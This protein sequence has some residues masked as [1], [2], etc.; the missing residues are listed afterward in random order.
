M[1]IALRALVS[2]ALLAAVIVH[3]GNESLL[4]S[5]RR[6][7]ARWWLLVP[8]LV[9]PPAFGYA[10]GVLR[11]RAL[12][13]AQ[14][15]RLGS[16]E[17]LRAMLIGTLFNQ[18]LP[19]SVGGDASRVWY[20]VRRV[21]QLPAVLS[22]VLLGRAM[23]VA[24]LCILVIT[25]SVI[26]PVWFS[27]I[28]ALRYCVGVLV[29]V[30]MAAAVAL[31]WIRAP[32]AEPGVDRFGLRRAW[33]KLATAFAR[34]RQHRTILAKTLLYSL[35]LQA[36][37]VLQYWLFSLCLGV[38]VSFDRFLVAVPLVSL[39]AM[40]PFSLNGIGIRECVMIWICAPLGITQGDAAVIAW[41]FVAGGL[42][43]AGVGAVVLSRSMT[44]GRA[45]TP[46]AAAL[47]RSG[48]N[49]DARG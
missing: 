10:M 8:S 34:F 30:L 2:V 17:V 15:V 36:E 39:A 43:Y 16:G 49:H 26:H 40:A 1:K 37:I 22:S 19:T 11:L 18:L 6:A 35:A 12:F 33:F 23:G 7:G 14:R 45:D 38:D 24:A 41:L 27:Q 46:P 48:T 25:G 5:L 31:A 29:G 28:P 47:D 9:M 42:F 13:R 32:A 44:R 4:D 3:V 20:M 21:G